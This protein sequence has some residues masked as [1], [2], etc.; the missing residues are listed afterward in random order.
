MLAAEQQG[1]GV[2][3][4]SSSPAPAVPPLT[5]SSLTAHLPPCVPPCAGL[6]QQA[7]AQEGS[8]QP[9]RCRKMKA[10][11]VRS[12]WI[13]W[14][15][16]LLQVL[17][18]EVQ[19]QFPVVHNSG[20]AMHRPLFE[21]V[22]R[23]VAAGRRSFEEWVCSHCAH[24]HRLFY[25][26][27]LQW[28]EYL[29]R[30]RRLLQHPSK[31]SAS[32][33]ASG[34]AP[35]PAAAAASTPGQQPAA[36]SAPAGASTAPG[37]GVAG[38]SAGQPAKAGRPAPS[39]AKAGKKA[40]AAAAAPGSKMLQTS[41]R[42][43]TVPRPPPP[44]ILGSS[45]GDPGVPSSGG[46]LPNQAA[47]SSAAA[48]AAPAAGG[49]QSGSSTAAGASG[50]AGRSGGGTSGGSAAAATAAAADG[51][52]STAAAAAAGG[53]T[54]AAG[55]GSKRKGAFEQ[56]LADFGAFDD[57]QGWAGYVPSAA[58]IIKLFIAQSEPAV[59]A[60]CYQQLQVGGELWKGDHSYKF[61]KCVRKDGQMVYAAAFTLMNVGRKVCVLGEGEWAAQGQ[62]ASCR[63]LFQML[64]L[65]LRAALS[66]AAQHSSGCGL[67][68]G[69]TTAAFS[70][71]HQVPCSHVC[72]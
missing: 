37:V 36:A 39:K 44:A 71:G 53:G 15:P 66:S 29:L 47:T 54:S 17:P 12:Q 34:G 68:A 70:D 19:Q 9:D 57:L 16:E 4:I 42:A 49:L 45:A 11:D 33:A 72:P 5:S 21:Q 46:G 58:S 61:V 65:L 41:L 67:V 32:S 52:G 48:A 13:S 59:V 35:P 23:E 64:R 43:F 25:D 28:L 62:A 14:D 60:A 8:S 6:A 38:T 10:G 2:A 30:C 56:Q 55:G 22:C 27:L 63:A 24:Q 18:A 51:G 69:S 1:S 26:G 40:A 20:I 50:A 31:R 7:K 3:L